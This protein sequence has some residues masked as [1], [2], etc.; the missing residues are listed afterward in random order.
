MTSFSE[1]QAVRTQA[2]AWYLDT[3]TATIDFNRLLQQTSLYHFLPLNDGTFA[4]RYY[5]KTIPAGTLE[6]R[7][8][9][10]QGFSKKRP[11]DG[12]FRDIF[13]KYGKDPT[14]GEYKQLINSEGSAEHNH[15]TR[16]PYT[17]ETA[18]R[19]AAEAASVL[20]FYVELLKAPPTK[21]ETSISMI[22][23]SLIPTD[24][25]YVSREV[26]ADGKDVT[27]SADEVYVILETRRDM[28][29]GRVEIVAQKDTQLAIYTVHADSPHQDV[30]HEDHSDTIH[31][32]AAHG[33][34]HTDV[35]YVNHQDNTH[36]DVAHGNVAHED[37]IYSDEGYSDYWDSHTDTAYVDVTYT[38]HDDVAYHDHPHVDTGHVDH[39]D[40]V[41]DDSHTDVTHIDSEV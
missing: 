6:L 31:E 15:G 34:S 24:K 1:L 22:G 11:N 4:A 26:R 25:L 16:E 13:L 9:D 5:R 41:H 36:S 37:G 2:V 35:A 33:D 18:L 10:Y 14:T 12:V 8:Y 28:A 29:E 27:I 7:D 20:A 23:R 30:A 3:D 19:D 32:D 17:V 39:S 40:T 21:I 38:D